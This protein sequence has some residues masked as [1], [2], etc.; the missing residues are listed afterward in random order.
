ML[1][2]FRLAMSAAVGLLLCSAP[3][4]PTWGGE[5]AV[6]TNSIGMEFSKS[7]SDSVDFDP[8]PIVCAAGF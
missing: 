4:R 1:A 6:I 7:W 2:T 8:S 5:P 3:C